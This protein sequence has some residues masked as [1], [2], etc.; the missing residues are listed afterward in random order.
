MTRLAN[1]LREMAARRPLLVA[2]DYD[3]V[4][5]PI[6]SDP[7]A[8]FPDPEAIAALVRL[9]TI[10]DVE[11]A[12]IS[13]RTLRDLRALSGE[14]SGVT[15]MGSHGAETA[16]GELLTPSRRDLRDRIASEMDQIASRFPGARV[17]VKPGGVAFHYRNVAEREQQTAARLVRNGP[18]GRPGLRVMEGKKIVEVTLTTTN[19]G[20][21]LA[22]MRKV[23]DAAGVVFLGDDVTD[24]DAFTTLGTDDIG[25]K[26]GPEPTAA[27]YRIQTQAEVAGVLRALADGCEGAQPDEP[28]A[29]KR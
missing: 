20:D 16:R 25:I 15:L 21:A 28:V 10:A 18:A 23:V 8:A 17:E 5:A 13:G 22:R 12:V 14:P 7:D 3:G 2:S 29:N 26:V 1:A 27:N 11:V 24:E 9:A 19:K 4:L 6:V